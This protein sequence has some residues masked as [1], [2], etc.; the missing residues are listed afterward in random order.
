MGKSG[1]GTVAFDHGG[2]SQVRRGS[3]AARLLIALSR[4]GISVSQ[5]PRLTSDPFA[6]SALLVVPIRSFV[7]EIQSAQRPRARGVLP[8]VHGA[9]LGR[10]RGGAHLQDAG[11][12]P[13]DRRHG[14]QPRVGRRPEISRFRASHTSLF[15]GGTFFCADSR[16]KRCSVDTT[17]AP[18]TER[19]ATLTTRFTD[20]TLNLN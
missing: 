18:M 19:V 8:P 4:A 16:T 1:A 15:A 3:L 11:Q 6:S 20:G 14:L 17:R 7:V 10:R 5:S 9:G 12:R 13:G 2:V